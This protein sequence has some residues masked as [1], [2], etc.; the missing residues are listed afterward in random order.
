MYIDDGG[1]YSLEY[2]EK[3]A[4]EYEGLPSFQ[5]AQIDRALAV[6]VKDPLPYMSGRHSVMMTVQLTR[7]LRA[8]CSLDHPKTT[9]RVDAFTVAP[10]PVLDED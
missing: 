9:I 3:S 6:V 4:K 10:K 2:T 1:K 7:R 8:V 5:R